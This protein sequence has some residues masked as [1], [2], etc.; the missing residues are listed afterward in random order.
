MKNS[1]THLAVILD[2]SGS[3]K[4]LM[5]DMIGGFNEFI[6]EQKALPGEATLTLVQFDDHYD[7]LHDF[8]DIQKVPVL[9][10]KVCYS[11]GWTAL[12][13]AVGVTITTVGGKIAAMPEDQRPAK[14][15][16]S[17][18]TDGAENKSKEY[19]LAKIREMIEE[20]RTKYSWEFTFTGL[21]VDSF[22]AEQ[23]DKMG[24]DPLLVR[25]M[26]HDSMG[27]AQSSEL[28]SRAAKSYRT[29][30]GQALREAYKVT[31]PSKN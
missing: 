16:I 8:I 15:L 2:R 17:I 14:V 28:H 3:M 19:T 20:Q 25:Q 7:V 26:S 31:P 5:S 22:A 10:E 29:G 24:I 9:T 13:D 1:Y 18:H 11:R 12:L 4:T 30:G 23:A 21:G 27:T 6:E